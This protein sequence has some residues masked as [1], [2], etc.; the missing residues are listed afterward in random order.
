MQ[1]GK[2]RNVWVLYSL[3]KKPK[4]K[5]IHENCFT[6]IH[7]KSIL[8][9]TCELFRKSLLYFTVKKK[10]T[11]SK[12]RKKEKRS[13]KHKVKFTRIAYFSLLVSFS[14]FFFSRFFSANNKNCLFHQKEY[15]LSLL[16]AEKGKKNNRRKI[17]QK[18]KKKL[19]CGTQKNQEKALTFLFPSS[20][21]KKTAH[22]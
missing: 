5:S 15:G 16:K 7:K 17:L 22:I 3:D 21:K 14:L 19:L 4:E 11:F 8:K 13:K 6:A 9:K 1:K 2:N 18:G 12:E 10:S 20:K